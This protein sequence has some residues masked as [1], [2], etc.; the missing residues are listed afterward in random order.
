[1]IYYSEPVATISTL[2]IQYVFGDMLWLL[3]LNGTTGKSFFIFFVF[4]RGNVRMVAYSKFSCDPVD[5]S[6]H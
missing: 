2:T 5:Q 3:S 1:M 6:V 4:M